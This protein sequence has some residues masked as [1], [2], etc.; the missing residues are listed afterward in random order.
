M[1]ASNL[2]TLWSLTDLSG[3]LAALQGVAFLFDS[4]KDGLTLACACDKLVAARGRGVV[5][6]MPACQAGDRGFKSRR[7]RCYN[8]R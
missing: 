1:G 3:K 5:V 6:N 8:I 2:G 7:P 4:K